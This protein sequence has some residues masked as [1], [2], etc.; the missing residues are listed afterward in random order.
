[1]AAALW[2]PK[3]TFVLTFATFLN[4]P[5]Y[6]AE[7]DSSYGYPNII[8]FFT[9]NL[10]L[11]DL[12]ILGS[13][14]QP[15]PNINR[16]MEEGVTFTR[17]YSQSSSISSRASILTGLLPP[18]TGIIRSKFLPFGGIPSVVS[19]GGLQ[20]KEITIAEVLKGKGYTTAF[21]GLWDLGVG[22][23]G[24]YLPIHQGFDSWYGVPSPHKSQ[25]F[26]GYKRR[27]NWNYSGW[28]VRLFITLLSCGF[29]IVSGVFYPNSFSYRTAVFCQIVL[30]VVLCFVSHL[31]EIVV[32]FIHT[33][34][35]VLY[36]DNNIIAQPYDVENITLHFTK[37]AATFVETSSK[38]E[39]P[40]FLFVSF[41]KLNQPI[42]TS[43]L[44]TNHCSSENVFSAAIC[45]LDW[46]IGRIMKTLKEQEVDDNTLILI[47]ST[48]GHWT[49]GSFNNCRPV[50]R[51]RNRSG[52]DIYLKG[53][54][55]I[56]LLNLQ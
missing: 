55:F 38:I 13:N 51:I 1:M 43:R 35:C 42:F 32:T 48:S 16:L 11:G 19:S 3:S 17:W 5:L 7:Y 14:S 4:F 6:F 24:E 46:S 41:M 50:N 21:V 36:M 31:I 45:E 27:S 2:L 18:R 22:K 9:D 37:K 44:F 39:K 23:K 54:C 30:A 34:S 40:F 33:R 25:C 49:D 47:T 56:K 8:I 53:N 28:N 26:R 20:N 12:N 52:G 29:I 10:S 15:T